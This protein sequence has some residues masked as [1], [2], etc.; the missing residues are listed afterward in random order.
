MQGQHQ[1][2]L[3]FSLI[4]AELSTFAVEDEVIGAVPVL[5]NIQPL[6]N[7]TSEAFQSEI[8]AQKDRFQGP[9]Q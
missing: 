9:T 5:D 1:Q 2:F 6:V 4:G 8:V 3:I 7:F